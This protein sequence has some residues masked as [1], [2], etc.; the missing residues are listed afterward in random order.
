MK[1]LILILC[2]AT[3]TLYAQNF[4]T[5]IEKHRAHYKKEF[6]TDEN[7]PLKKED[8]KFLQFYAANSSYIVKTNF[9]KISDT[10]GFDMLTHSGKIKKYYV[11]GS[12]T[13]TL[14][15]QACRL[16]IYQSAQ[17]KTTKGLEDYLFIPFTDETNS[18]S[19]FG[20]GRYLDFKEKDIFNNHLLIDFNKC[21][22]PYCAYKGGYNCPI[23]PKENDLKM[24]I[25]AGEKTFGKAILE[26]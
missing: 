16:F 2:C 20:G 7:S 9:T 5:E 4:T 21:Y 15:Q 19:T 17:L 26:Q 13:F 23:P 11:F 18:V 3:Q 1:Y 6:L 22:N 10:I 24:T 14:K 25:E 8:L 12:V